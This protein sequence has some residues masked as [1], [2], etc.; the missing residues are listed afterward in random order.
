LYCT[1]FY[2]S[3]WLLLRRH[4]FFKLNRFYLISTLFL[5]LILPLIQFTDTVVLIQP[6]AGGSSET[7]M[8]LADVSPRQEINWL[9]ILLIIYGI[10]V[11]I[12]LVKLFTGFYRLYFLQKQGERIQLEGYILIL[13]PETGSYPKKLSS[14]SFFNLLVVF[15]HDYE[16]CFDIILQHENV[17]IKQG[18]SFDIVLIEAFKAVFWF[19]PFILFYKYSLQEIHEFLAD[20]QAGSKDSY[21]NF[22]VSYAQNAAFDSLGNNFFNNFL[23]KNRIK[24]IYRKSTSYWSISK[25]ALI[26]PIIGFT[27]IKTAAHNQIYIKAEPIVKIKDPAQ[28][29][30]IQNVQTP[31]SVFKKRSKQLITYISKGSIK[32]ANIRP[33]KVKS[34]ESGDFYRVSKYQDT[35]WE[36]YDPKA[37]QINYFNKAKI[38][39]IKP[40]FPAFEKL[41][42]E[43]GKSLDLSKK[44]APKTELQHFTLIT[45]PIDF[46]PTSI[47]KVIR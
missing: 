7:S 47:K 25:Y 17:H 31:D 27:V 22:L 11:I 20:R 15:N 16:N 2:V 40:F 35:L 41:G 45:R 24:M 4:T 5:S 10:G 34:Y 29:V 38:K 21:A 19:N 14:F 30:N 46:Y 8:Y 33:R 9:Q 43:F 42:K 3:Y 39:R 13:L 36:A 26:I 32:K 28:G 44:D 18:H 6:V 23:L 37:G 12:M 1:L